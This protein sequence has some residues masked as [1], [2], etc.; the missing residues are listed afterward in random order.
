MEHQPARSEYKKVWSA[1]S[2]TEDQAKLH[3]IGVTDEAALQSAGEET[4]RFLQ[5]TVGIGKEDVVLEIGSGIG[6]VGKVVAPLCGKW[7]GCDVASNMLSLTA[8]RLKDL[9]NVELVEL[10]GYD[11][12]GVA[13]TSV[14]FSRGNT[15]ENQT[16][17]YHSIFNR[18]IAL[19]ALSFAWSAAAQSQTGS[20]TSLNA[21]DKM[22]VKK[23]AK[24]GMMEVAMGK[25]AS[26]RGQS[27]DVTKF[28]ER[29][30]IDH[31]KANEDLT[32]IAEKKR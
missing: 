14:R 32:S 10:S 4:L 18:A 26:E 7:I 22:F 31:S 19:G 28:G 27:A 30:V 24:G 25:L 21:K 16:Y 2:T 1:L 15:Y 29:M 9:S 11:L 17:C 23:S 13:D 8:E 3:V 6:R 5:D 20:S 12:S